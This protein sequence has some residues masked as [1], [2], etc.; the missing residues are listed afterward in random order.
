[1]GW[2]H[3]IV[4][5]ELL[6]DRA[7]DDHIVHLPVA[8]QRLRSRYPAFAMSL[9][10]LLF[11]RRPALAR[12]DVYDEAK[13]ADGSSQSQRRGSSLSFFP[14]ALELAAGHI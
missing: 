13:G 4:N 12:I 8:C 1:M 11:H 14:A 2:H 6:R 9:R 7:H 3:A 10:E 5:L